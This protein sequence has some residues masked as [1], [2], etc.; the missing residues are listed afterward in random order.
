MTRAAELSLVAYDNNST[1]TQFVQGWLM[2]DRFVAARTA[3]RAVRISVGESIP[4]GPE[5]CASAAAYH[6]ARAG[7]LVRAL[8]V[9]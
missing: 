7:R 5:L 2:H 3:R 4:A 8:F 1:E 9:G 6:D